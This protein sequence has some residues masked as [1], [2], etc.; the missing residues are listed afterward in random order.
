MKHKRLI[1]SKRFTLHF[2]PELNWGYFDFGFM[3]MF[4]IGIFTMTWND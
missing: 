3:W 1:C 2:Y 4:S